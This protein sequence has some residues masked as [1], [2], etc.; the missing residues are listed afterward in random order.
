MAYSWYLFA[1]YMDSSFRGL[2]LLSDETP[3][4]IG[5]GHVWQML[6]VFSGNTSQEA[7]RKARTALMNC[8]A[9]A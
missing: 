9:T 1:E 3:T 5:A 2:R 6:A 8:I 4:S 7:Y